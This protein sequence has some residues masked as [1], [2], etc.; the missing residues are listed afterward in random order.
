MA[1]LPK[2]CSWGL[3]E[4]G[5][6]YYSTQKFPV[7]ESYIIQ[8]KHNMEQNFPGRFCNWMGGGCINTQEKTASCFR[9]HNL[10][11]Q[12][13]TTTVPKPEHGLFCIQ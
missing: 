8:H 4:R 13:T 7:T 11:G 9:K 3:L 2:I 5:G 10:N 12:T 1:D 6:V